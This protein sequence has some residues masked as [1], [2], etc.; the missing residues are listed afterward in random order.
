MKVIE[1]QQEETKYENIQ[2]INIKNEI[3]TKQLT[4]AG[5]RVAKRSKQKEDKLSKATKKL[6]EHRTQVVSEGKRKTVEII[7]VNKE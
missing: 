1:I 5:K 7:E 4:E 2:D 6:V 3:I